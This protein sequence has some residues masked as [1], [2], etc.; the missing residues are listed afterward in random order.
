MKLLFE[1][2]VDAVKSKNITIYNYHDSEIFNIFGK[3][4]WTDVQ[5]FPKY[6]P[7]GRYEKIV[8]DELDYAVKNQPDYDNFLKRIENSLELLSVPCLILVPLNFLNDDDIAT[9]LTFSN[10]IRLFK[11][12]KPQI[13]K[14]LLKTKSKKSCLE[15]YFEH[16]VYAQLSREH[17]LTV[18]DRN[19]FNYPILTIFVNNIDWKVEIES[20]RIVSAAY[21]FIRMIEFDTKLDCGGWGYMMRAKRNPAHV[22]GVYYNETHV[23]PKPPY[24][25]GYGYSL[26]FQCSP[27]LDISTKDFVNNKAHLTE[28]TTL[29]TQYINCC[30]KD[31][32]LLSQFSLTKIR[33][34]QNAVQMYN[35]AYENASI[36]KYDEALVLLLVILESLFISNSGNKK[37]K[38][39]KALV[40]FFQ[41]D[42]NFSE[43]LIRQLI[44]ST[45]KLR[46]KFVH[47][48]MGIGNEYV[49]LK[50]LNDYQGVVMGMKPFAH[51]ELGFVSKPSR[52]LYVLFILV[53][54]VLRLYTCE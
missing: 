9:D 20:G 14:G 33:Q 27:I 29:L 10:N 18:K 43:S 53:G 6:T 11:T 21:A 37:E 38:V 5:K 16:T 17:I 32:R 28:F 50:S 30:F 23:S 36:E 51:S 19:F 1:K 25:S 40:D 24:D 41:G 7:D 42:S 15:E 54:R 8:F 4:L 46:N 47:E 52:E 12:D 44:T 48:G 3:M 22:Y 45:Y 35:S 2:I 49:Y 39:I 26:R 13:E 31:E 34:W